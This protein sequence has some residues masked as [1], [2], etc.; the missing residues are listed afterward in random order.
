MAPAGS[1]RYACGMQY[2]PI[3]NAIAA[4]A[5]AT[6]RDRFDHRLEVTHQAAPCRSCLRISR[7]PEE[8]ILLSYQPLPDR[9]PYAEVGPIF[10]HAGECR[11]Y[12]EAESFPADFAERRLVLRAY[13][14]AG[15]I[16]DAVVAAPGTAP[17]RAARFF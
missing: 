9:V 17:D 16:V 11:P 5:R 10:I 14:D 13:G 1:V 12:D 3:P 7:E 8:L 2:L 6:L 15:E 4:E